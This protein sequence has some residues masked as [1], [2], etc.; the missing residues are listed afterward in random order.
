[1]MTLVQRDHLLSQRLRAGQDRG[2]GIGNGH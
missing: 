2:K 1:V